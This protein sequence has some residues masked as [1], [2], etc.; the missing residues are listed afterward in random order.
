MVVAV[1]G[2]VSAGGCVER[3]VLSGC[4]DT[5]GMLKSPV[6]GGRAVG[7]GRV[8]GCAVGRR[9]TGE[10]GEREGCDRDG[11]WEAGVGLFRDASVGPPGCPTLWD[12]VTRWMLLAED[13]REGPLP[14]PVLDDDDE[15]MDDD[16]NDFPPEPEVE[17]EPNNL[18]APAAAGRPPA[19]NGGITSSSSMLMTKPISSLAR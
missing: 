17:E 10:A 6:C 1:G 18:P 9:R 13:V 12:D 4:L 7:G 16:P 11:S 5:T 15:E 14:K 3:G 19:P 2:G 8:A